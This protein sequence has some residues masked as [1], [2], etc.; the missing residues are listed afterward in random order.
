MRH[1]QKYDELKKLF[2]AA[3]KNLHFSNGEISTGLMSYGEM[4][5]LVKPLLSIP[6]SKGINLDY[7]INRTDAVEFIIETINL[8]IKLN[9]IQI[10]QSQKLSDIKYLNHSSFLAT[11]DTEIAKLPSTDISITIPLPR[12]APPAT[13]IYIT[14]NIVL[15]KGTTTDYK[16]YDS[17]REQAKSIL[18]RDNNDCA[19]LTLRGF[20]YA[21]QETNNPS[22]QRQL[23][24]Y[25]SLVMAVEAI[26]HPLNIFM[27]YRN[28]NN[29]NMIISTSSKHLSTPLPAS[30]NDSIY[31]LAMTETTLNDIGDNAIIESILTD[32]SED[33]QK[34]RSA[35][36]WLFDSYFSETIATS[37]INTSIALE[38]LFS[39]SGRENVTEKLKAKF[40]Y[41]TGKNY[42]ERKKLEELM[43]RFYKYRSNIVHGRGEVDTHD[44]RNTVEK[45]RILLEIEISKQ[46][47][48][49][50][51][52]KIKNRFLD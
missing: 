4:F 35:L 30:I 46:I 31:S 21:S 24:I 18:N 37:T 13:D 43:D 52:R 17:V 47:E 33:Y 38:S 27:H 34:I 51:K 12:T 49:L 39:D 48:S 6:I 44:L 7:F 19:T 50:H 15:S 11:L 1:L 40:A 9:N 25:K 20:G 23:L 16:R 22:T 41:S 5:D 29:Y 42:G 45:I 10:P 28:P 14:S 26:K 36:P 2:H 3:T 8:F 32:P